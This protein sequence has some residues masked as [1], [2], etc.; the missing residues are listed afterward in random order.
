MVRR[1]RCGDAARDCSRKRERFPAER[2]PLQ[3]YL[4]RSAIRLYAQC[5]ERLGYDMSLGGIQL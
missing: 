3:C 4:K 2:M 5:D 1:T